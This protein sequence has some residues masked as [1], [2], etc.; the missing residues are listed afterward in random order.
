MTFMHGEA[1]PQGAG[2]TVLTVV[3]NPGYPP[4]HAGITT[5]TLNPS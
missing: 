5:L 1:L 4:Q 2:S 3:V